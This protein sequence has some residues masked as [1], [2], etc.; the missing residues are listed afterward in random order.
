M[1][2][3]SAQSVSL[4]AAKKEGKVIVYGTIVPQVMKLIENGFEAK[5]GVN[6]EYWRGD[7]TKVIDR[8]LTEW[9][10]GKPGF[11]MVIGARGPLSLAQ[12]RRRLCQVYAGERGEFPGQVPRQG[13]T[14]DG[15]AHH[16]GG[17]PDQHRTG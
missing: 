13:R 17:Y 9:R 7:A 15:V 14:V 5:Y 12:G 16:A 6:I 11:D 2:Q 10:A 8:V 1:A 3:A 4:E